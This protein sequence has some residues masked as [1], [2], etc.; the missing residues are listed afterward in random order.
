VIVEL[1]ELLQKFQI[2]SWDALIIGD[3]STIG[4]A[5]KKSAEMGWAS[6]MLDRYTGLWHS[7]IGC[8]TSSCSI[9]IAELIGV[10]WLLKYH[11]KY[12]RRIGWSGECLTVH[13]FSDNNATVTSGNAAPADRSSKHE[14]LW[15]AIDWVS[16]DRERYKLVFH[17]VD[18][19]T[20]SVH[21]VMDELSVSAR[22]YA[23]NFRREAIP[24]LSQFLV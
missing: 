4:N 11:A 16:R 8:T 2:D 13:V 24:D 19:E 6:A 18:R 17:H 22:E 10:W 20:V 5:Q 15:R 3:G 21:S 23:C 14:D 9:G 1:K 12:C 7:A